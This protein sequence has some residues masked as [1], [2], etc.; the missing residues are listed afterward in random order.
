MIAVTVLRRTQEAQDI[1]GFELG[2]PDGG[3]HRLGH[4]H[5]EHPGDRVAQL[6]H[7]GFSQAIRELDP[8]EVIDGT[9]L[10]RSQTLGQDDLFSEQR[11]G[12]VFTEQGIGQPWR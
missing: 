3:P 12:I 11:H 7:D 1:A 10:T 2:R 9:G 8:V 5:R 4:A 6:G